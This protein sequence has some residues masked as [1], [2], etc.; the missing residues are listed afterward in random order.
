MTFSKGD[1]TDEWVCEV[2]FC[3]KV[4]KK[5][6]MILS[7]YNAYTPENTAKIGRYNT[8]NGPA[9]ATRHFTEPKRRQQQ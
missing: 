6:N 1:G 8:K 7:T 5:C 2:I 9:W 3:N 4:G